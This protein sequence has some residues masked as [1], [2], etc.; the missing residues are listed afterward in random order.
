M[1][2]ASCRLAPGLAETP[3]GLVLRGEE[4]EEEGSGEDKGGKE[5]K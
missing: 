2:G 1:P 5:L 3:V 4:A